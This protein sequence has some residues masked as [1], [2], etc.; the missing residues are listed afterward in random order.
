MNTKSTDNQKPLY[1][2]GSSGHAKVVEDIAA[3]LGVAVGGRLGLDDCQRE[4]D[5]VRLPERVES[6]LFLAVGDN[7]RRRRMGENLD[8]D[9]PVLVAPSA[10]VSPS[11]KIGEGTVVMQNAVIQADCQIGR[12]CIVNTSSSIDHECRLADYV[13]VSPGAVL[14]GNVEVGECAWIGA[15]A[16]VVP[17]VRIG[18]RAIVGAGATVRHDVPAGATVFGFV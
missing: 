3:S 5:G 12:H 8:A 15:G 18:A 16:V 6:P 9:F 1:L 11:A 13:H 4:V 2:L 14:C 17:G 10:I 7:D